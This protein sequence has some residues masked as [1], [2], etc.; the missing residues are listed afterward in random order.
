MNGP[1]VVVLINVLCSVVLSSS[2]L[3]YVVLLFLFCILSGRR[4]LIFCPKFS[5]GQLVFDVYYKSFLTFLF[6]FCK[7]LLYV[8]LYF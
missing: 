5:E 4:T 7:S 1:F 8:L 6:I 2:S 3:W